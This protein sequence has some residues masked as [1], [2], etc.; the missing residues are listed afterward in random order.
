M[1]DGPGRDPYWSQCEIDLRLAPNVRLHV[2]F[3]RRNT[4][5]EQQSP[6]RLL[7]NYEVASE[8]VTVPR[9]LESPV[10]IEC[11]FKDEVSLDHEFK[12]MLGQVLLVHVK[13]EAVIDPARLRIDAAS[14]DLIGRMEGNWYARTTSR[15]EA[16]YISLE[17][18]RRLQG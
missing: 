16:P 3:D 10:A 4:C 9:I 7:R 14:L 15:V 18:W 17:E 2:N 8:R 11:A 1:D 6:K 13:D 5:T 12:L